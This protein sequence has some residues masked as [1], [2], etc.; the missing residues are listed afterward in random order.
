MLWLTASQAQADVSTLNFWYED[1]AG[2]VNTQPPGWQDSTQD[3]TF[4]AE[5]TYLP[6][7]T[8]TGINRTAGSDTYGKVL[9]PLVD[10]NV[11]QYPQIEINVTGL[12][13]TATWKIGIQEVGTSNHWD[14]CAS[15]SAPGILRVNYQA[16][17][18]WHGQKQFFVQVTLE[19]DS[20]QYLTMD[21]VCVFGP[22]PYEIWRDD[23]SGTPGNQPDGWQD[24]T[25]NGSFNTEMA[26][27]ANGTS[28]AVSRTQDATW[29]MVYSPVITCDTSIFTQVEVN[30]V[31]ASPDATW[32]VGIHEIG[33]SNYQ[34]LSS[35]LSGTGTFVFEYPSKMGWNNTR[36]F[37]LQVTVE[38]GPGRYVTLDYVSVHQAGS[39]TTVTPT[40]AVTPQAT[41]TPTVT[42]TVTWTGTPTRTFTPTST[43]TPTET[44]APTGTRTSTSTSTPTGTTPLTETHTATLTS[45]PTIT[46]TPTAT[47]TATLTNTP[48]VTLT[49][50]PTSTITPVLSHSPTC[51][52]TPTYTHTATPT[53]DVI[54]LPADF[55]YEDFS[56]VAGSLPYAWRDATLDSGFNA[57]ISYSAT[58]SQASVK[59]TAGT[60][61]WGMVYSPPIHCDVNQYPQLE[62]HVTGL[63]SSAT[64]KVGIQEAG[65]AN[66]WDLCASQTAP[67]ILRANYPAITGWSG[68]KRFYVQL[69][70]EGDAQQS[71]VVDYV[72]IF[73]TRRQAADAQLIKVSANEPEQLA[74]NG[75]VIKIKGANYY[76]SVHGWE[77]MW[78]EWNP[79]MIDAELAR[80]SQLGINSIR[81]F[82]HYPESGG[83][84][85]T[86]DALAKIEAFLYYA[87]KYG[88]KVQWA[89]FPLDRDYSPALRSN[90]K[91][92]LQTILERFRDD[93]RIMGWGVTNELDLY[94]FQATAAQETEAYEWHAEMA[95]YM[96]GVDARHL[97][98]SASSRPET[99]KRM[100]LTSVDVLDLHTGGTESCERGMIM[101]ARQWMQQKVSVRPILFNEF[102]MDYTTNPTP[103]AVSA[104]YTRVLTD[105]FQTDVAGGMVWALND[106]PSQG[107]QWGLFTA[108]GVLHA[109]ASVVRDAYTGTNFL[110]VA[111][112][113][114]VASP[115][116]VLPPVVGQERVLLNAQLP[117]LTSQWANAN[118]RVNFSAQDSSGGVWVNLN[119]GFI[120]GTIEWVGTFSADMNQENDLR[121]NVRNSTGTWYAILGHRSSGW[122]VRLQVGTLALGGVEYNLRHYVPSSL[123]SGLQDFYIAVGVEEL[124]RGQGTGSV[125]VENASLVTG[126]RPNPVAAPAGTFWMDHF[127]G[128]FW[129]QPPQWQD[130]SQRASDNARIAYSATA[131]CAAVTRTTQDVWGKV[132]SPVLTCNVADFNQLEL[133]IAGVS[134]ATT[135]KVGV[136]DMDGS[137]PYYELNPSSSQTG[138][139][140][141]NVQPTTGWNSTKNFRVQIT[142]EGAAG[143]HLLLDSVRV[144]G[145]NAAALVFGASTGLRGGSDAG[146]KLAAVYTPAVVATPTMTA[147]A[148]STPW[149]GSNRVVAYPNPGRAQIRFAYSSQPGDAQMEV[150]IY[151]ISGERVAWVRESLNAGAVNIVNW[152]C[153]SH[154]PGVY[155]A[156]MVVK[157]SYGQ[158]TYKEIK[159][160]AVVR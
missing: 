17:T 29:G 36:A 129:V 160:I 146:S 26:L 12:S 107:Q 143:T 2:T 75:T 8:Q 79:D 141:W 70:V 125:L 58:V 126:T 110:N 108:A 67:G 61:P 5:I 104:F 124:P 118:G 52:I 69:T 16:I 115:L 33:T 84:N 49:P 147:T 66:Y 65:A 40:I 121:L 23:L 4:H 130:A 77:K 103:A 35:S 39:L 96:K 156:R 102:G 27:A 51:T 131:S 44:N 80:A 113:S 71:V 95:A 43:A 54:T 120:Y 81:T 94:G 154:A 145:T 144:Y 114:R 63:S 112:V 72:R 76:P 116:Q 78:T 57:V 13:S 30:V 151:A 101:H 62:I 21:S 20:Q 25:Q 9:S 24:K 22:R 119:P 64:W 139:F 99:V 31:S 158:E 150:S 74:L 105:L 159:K 28:A 53:P 45:T 32:K 18:G 111:A 56:G 19:G 106:I 148:S 133:K 46:R 14:L 127:L 41:F 92:H 1:F 86:P 152:N 48:T 38:G 155:L 97:I 100:D 15:Q 136:Q 137:M 93:E 128:T 142:V 37:N 122:W 153:A 60:A 88:L 149:L 42:R 47:R 59:R 3:S 140:T 82:V 117:G 83:A 34:D 90:M 68:E 138:T 134:P 10:C 135:W 73:G 109:G 55:W 123:Q 85:V 91:R 7:G 132:F 6:T 11:D 50:T 87:A 89:F 157:D 98:I